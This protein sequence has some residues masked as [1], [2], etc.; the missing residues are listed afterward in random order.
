MLARF[1]PTRGSGGGGS[2]D[3]D[4]DDH[5]FVNELL[6]CKCDGSS[7]RRSISSLCNIS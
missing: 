2:L 7:L 3:G 1:V 6:R 5:D 4:D